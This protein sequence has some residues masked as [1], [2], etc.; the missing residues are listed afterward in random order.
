MLVFIP[1]PMVRVYGIRI[2]F[3]QHAAPGRFSSARESSE[4]FSTFLESSI[5]DCL[6]WQLWLITTLRTEL[7]HVRM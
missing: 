4:F 1:I 5:I 2:R 6:I 3:T 7:N